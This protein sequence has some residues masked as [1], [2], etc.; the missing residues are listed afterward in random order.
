MAMI[1]ETLE[2]FFDSLREMRGTQPLDLKL[3]KLLAELQPALSLEAQKVL[4]VYFSLL[5]DGNTC[6]SL[7]PRKL[8]AKWTF[9]WNGLKTQ[10]K[11]HL[12]EGEAEN[13][14]DAEEFAPVF[15]KG[16]SDLN[17]L[18]TVEEKSVNGSTRIRFEM[19]P[20]C[21]ECRENEPFLFADKYWQAK[22]SILHV[23]G[24]TSERAVFKKD[25]N[26]F[27]GISKGSFEF[28]KFPLKFAQENSVRCGEKNNLIITGGPG[29]GKT[30]VVQFLLWNLFKREPGKLNWSL[31]FVA[32]SGKAANRLGDV[33]NLDDISEAEKK[34]HPEIVDKFK[35]VE[36]Q[37]LHRLLKFN[38]SKNSFSYN[39]NNRLPNRSIFVV[40]EASMIDVTLF[41][42]FLEAL[43]ER[44]EDYRLFVLGDKNQLPS[45]E[46]GAVLGEVLG[47]RPDATVELTE[48]NRFP[49]DSP[50]GRFAKAIQAETDE[51]LE[52]SLLEC[53]ENLSKRSLEIDERG[54]IFSWEKAD[55]D[56]P[57]TKNAVR[58]VSLS[59]DD[60]SLKKRDA[61]ALVEKILGKWAD[62]FCADL[63]NL[64]SAVNPTKE[65]AEGEIGENSE[66]KVR[67]ELWK[68]AEMARILS[69]E[70][71]GIQ[72][73]ETINRIICSKIRRKFSG[74]EN[75]FASRYFPGQVLMFTRNQ[76]DFK[77]FNGDSGIV[78]KS[79]EGLD[80]LMIQKGD[81]F[82]CYPL[83]L[84]PGDSLET[85]FAITIHKSQGSGYGNILMFLPLQSGHPL[86]NRQILY[87]GVT[88]VKMGA[89]VPGSLTLVASKARLLE[90][91]R[92]RI[93]RDTGIW[94][95]TPLCNSFCKGF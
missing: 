79:V 62:A 6:I 87:T 35:N 34:S 20:L 81:E 55:I 54:K 67:Q 38:P 37:T 46:A 93:E 92:T 60:A 66:Y 5:S 75:V 63:V 41:A 21:V 47:I 65:I 84:F 39:K 9:K 8:L 4:L 50:V 23:F 82:P 31:Y 49:D 3:V 19:L 83:S 76:A 30:T 33:K 14:L 28:G 45:V 88:R 32:P 15:E 22:E 71:R 24:D 17:A 80:Y 74:N 1:T 43:P 36:G 44:T 64:A 56:W 42:A 48:S 10:K 7:N 69:A 90:A 40:D 12:A 18:A 91:R 57:V 29:T 52:N 73:V 25:A 11:T 77:L 72:G 78:V 89:K 86:L 53:A 16:C 95:K 51:A 58:F 2:E 61:E 13:F 59:D 27:A 68:A 26:V 94:M 70:R 85:A